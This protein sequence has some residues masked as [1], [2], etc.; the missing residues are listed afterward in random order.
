M[1]QKAIDELNKI[2]CTEYSGDNAEALRAMDISHLEGLLH[3][4]LDKEQTNEGVFD[5]IKSDY[6][7]V[8]TELKTVK[9]A[10]SDLQD[11][12]GN[13]GRYFSGNQ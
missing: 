3:E 4:A 13:L 5:D 11:A 8:V 12:V 1:I 2:N 9:E 7:D 6:D 10:M